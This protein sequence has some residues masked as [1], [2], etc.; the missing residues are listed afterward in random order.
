MLVSNHSLA[1]SVGP[2]KVIWA[3]FVNF[4]L[5]PISLEILMSMVI[6][7]HFSPF[8]VVSSLLVN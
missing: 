8:D 4:S 1:R 7:F 6:L 2:H 3:S 5:R